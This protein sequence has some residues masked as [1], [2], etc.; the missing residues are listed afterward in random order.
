MNHKRLFQILLVVSALVIIGLG[1]GVKLGLDRISEE[2]AK[3]S[4]KL[5]QLEVADEKLS[6]TVRTQTQL[7]QLQF[8]QTIADEVLPDEKAQP[9][10]VGQILLIAANNNIRVNNITFSGQSAQE[11]VAPDLTQAEPL[12]EIPGVFTIPLNI[13]INGDYD[14]MLG[15]LRDLEQNRRKI[16][17]SGITIKPVVGDDGRPTKTV[18][19][20]IVVDVYV[21]PVLAEGASI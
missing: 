2:E 16:Q 8:I 9:E 3:I 10:L 6:L 7:E 20:T 18:S 15:M 14:N 17:V 5:A 19:A 12:P 21:R 11:G 4:T 13:T 1:F